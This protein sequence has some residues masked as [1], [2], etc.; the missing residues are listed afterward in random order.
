MKV[1]HDYVRSLSGVCFRITD[2]MDFIS[3]PG[4]ISYLL[5]TKRVSEKHFSNLHKFI[6]MSAIPYRMV[7]VEEEHRECIAF[8][9]MGNKEEK[10]ELDSL[11]AW[12]ELSHPEWTVIDCQKNA[13]IPSIIGFRIANNQFHAKKLALHGEVLD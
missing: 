7:L 8:V 11:M 3:E 12:V 1:S 13:E 6:R 2:T 4:K 9:L 10:E 5:Y